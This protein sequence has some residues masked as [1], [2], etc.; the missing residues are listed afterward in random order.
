MYF[1]RVLSCKTPGKAR[2]LSLNAS[3]GCMFMA[4]PAILIGA[5]GASTGNHITHMIVF[6]V[7]DQPSIQ[8]L[9]LAKDKSSIQSLIPNS[10]IICSD[11]HARK[12]RNCI[13]KISDWPTV[14]EL[15]S[16]KRQQPCVVGDF[17]LGD[18]RSIRW[19]QLWR[20]DIE[21]FTPRRSSFTPSTT[22]PF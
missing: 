20:S 22:N 6:L 7:W 16:V 12:D 14:P 5:I 9:L 1:Q 2:I 19:K 15:V 8:L 18:K 13:G 10:L 17:H 4:I 21:I 3:F 11:H